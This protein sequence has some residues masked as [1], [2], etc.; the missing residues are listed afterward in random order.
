MRIVVTGAGGFVGRRLVELLDDHAVVAVDNDASALPV[1]AIVNQ[2]GGDLCDAE[3]IEEAFS[4][5]CDAV[6]HLAR[7]PGGAAEENPELARQV[8]VD[9]TMVLSAKAAG[10][11]NRPRFVFASSIAVF[12][13]S[14]PACVDDSTPL[15]PT[16]LYGAHKVMIEQW[17]ATLTRRGELDAISL[18]LSGV[19]ARPR[20]PSGMKSAFLS[21]MFHALRA[22]EAFVVP[23]SSAAT[24]WLTSIDCAA[25]NFA[26]AL[27]T[28]LDST[29]ENRAI[30]L[31]ALQVRISDLV[32]AIVDSADGDSAAVSY[33]SDAQL[34]AAFGSYPPL[35]TPTA[36]KLGFVNDGDVQ[37]L[38][39]KALARMAD[40]RPQRTLMEAN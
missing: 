27:V 29:P 33:E 22:G 16:M 31:P 39:D 28:C 8:N 6:V 1:L 15:A 37:S 35:L 2:I 11:G 38:V 24:C 40:P 9:A 30:N 19:V 26:H 14:L 10:T 32:A 34:E 5:G 36:D 3:E 13:G 4:G 12:G 25:A 7:V 17:L 21:D 23:V 20:G 18:R